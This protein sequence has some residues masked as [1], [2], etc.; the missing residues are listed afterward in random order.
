MSLELSL[1]NETLNLQGEDH[2]QP[3]QLTYPMKNCRQDVDLA[4]T[5]MQTCPVSGDMDG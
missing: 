2:H 4:S 5:P 1:L 3:H